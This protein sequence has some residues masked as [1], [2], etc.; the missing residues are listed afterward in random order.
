MEKEFFDLT[1]PQKSIWLTEQYYSNTNINNVCGTFYSSEKLDF[2]LLKKSLNIFLRNNDSFKIKLCFTNDEIKQYFCEIEDI[3]FE[4]IDV[5][6]KEEQTTLENKVA[7]KVFNLI[8]SFLFEIVLF[9]YP[10]NSGG[11]VINSHH[12]ISD[13]WSN[14][15]VANEVAL[16]YD[17]VKNNEPYEKS[18]EL[19]YKAYLH[20]EKDYL[21]STKFEKDK[22]YWEEVFSTVPEVATIPS[23]KNNEKDDDLSANRLLLNVN[24]KLLSNIQSY[25]EKNKISLFN[26]FMAVFALYLGRVSNLDEF[27]IGTPILNR[28][29][30]KEKQITG[31]F[32]NTLPLKIN[33]MHDKTF[34][35]NLKNIAINSMA[36]LRHQ[37]YSYQ[38]IIED[39]R[40]KDSNLPM[41]YN[42][43]YSYQITKMNE[44]MDALNHTTSWTFNKTISENLDIHMFEWNESNTINIAYDYRINKYDEQDILALHARILHI[45]EQILENENILLKDI[46]IVTPEEKHKILYEF[47]NTKVDYPRDKTIVDLFEEQVEKTPDNIAVV[48]E[49]QKLTYRELNEKANQLARYMLLEYNVKP[50]DT[51]GVYLKKNIDFIISIF[52][53]LKCNAVYMPIFYDYPVDR[54]SYMINNS[55]CKLL[56]T[57]SSNSNIEL[58]NTNSIFIDSI[59][60]FNSSS[61]STNINLAITVDSLAYIIYTSGSTGNPKGVC[62]SH[63]NL[64]NFVCSFNKYFKII[65]D[66]DSFLSSTNVAFDVSIWEIFVPLLNGAKLYLNT[67][68]II[69]D[70]ILYCNNIIKYNINALYIPP[71]ILNDVFAILKEKKYNKISK[72]LVGVEPITNTTLNKYI[73]LNPNIIIVNGYGPTETTICATALE[74]KK[75]LSDAHTISIGKPLYNNNI[76]ILSHNMLCP[77]NT[78]GEVFVSGDGVGQGYLNDPLKTRG[79]FKKDIFFEGHTMYSTGD[80][81]F[82][83][84]DGTIQFIG[85]KDNQIKLHGYRIELNEIDLTLMKLP[86]ISKSISL[87]IN[88]NIVAYYISNDNLSD[89][90]IKKFLKKELPFY[91]IPTHII[92]LDNWP[93]TING[94]IDKTRLPVPK[95][96]LSNTY[97]APKTITEQTLCNI[98]CSLFDKEKISMDENFF[99][100]GGDS[101]TAIKLQTEALKNGIYINYA[102][103]FANPT[104]KS[105]SDY[106][107]TLSEKEIVHTIKK[108]EQ[109]EYYPISSAQKRMYYSSNLDNN[110]TLYNIAGGII[111]DKLLD[112]NKLQECFNILI[113]RHEALRTHFDI[114]NDEVV[115]VIDDNI[116]FKLSL[117]N[118]SSD[119]LNNIYTD[120]VKP[121]DLSKAPLF[122]VKL[123]KLNNNKELL[124]LDM[125]HIISDG[126]SLN[127]LLQELCDLYN[128]STL[129]EKQIDYK[130]FTLWEREQFETE[131]F[132]KSKEYWLN[133]FKDEIPL[134]NMPTNNPRPSIQRFVGSN[135]YTQLSK[136]VFEKVNETAKKLNITPYMLLLA[137]YYILLSKYTSQDDIVVGTPIVGRELPE[138]SNILG[139]FVNTLALRNKIDHNLTFEEFSKSIKENCLNSFKNQIYPFDMLVK[140]LNIKRDTSRNP[141]FDVMFVYQNNGYPNINFN[142]TK[143]EYFV[144][145]NNI[146]KFDLTLEIIPIDNEYSLRF[147]YCTKLFNE[148]FIKRLSSHYLNILN[149]IL[150]NN[151]IK[152]AD[153]DMLSKEERNKIL[154]EFNNIEAETNNDTF[155]SLF[156]E[157]VKKYPN[158]IALICDNKSLT[159]SELNKKAN[160]L[161]HFLINNNVKQNDIVAIMT[162]RSLET[163]VCML[164]ILKAGAAFV[165]MDPTYPIE[166]TTYYLNDCKAKCLLKQKHLEIPVNN[167]KNIY[168]IDLDITD[169]YGKNTNNP[170]LNIN[171]ESLSYIIYTSGSTG[172]P[173]G[174]V[175]NHIGLANMCKAMTLVLDYLKD[176]PNHTLLS[177]TSTPFDIFVYEI[178]VP[179]SHGMKIVLA[180]NAEHRNPKLVDVLIRKYNVDV[181]TVTPSL[182]KINY[183]NREPNSALANV[184]NMVFGG[185]PL[186]EKF[187]HDLKALSSDITIYNIY[188]P[189]EITVLSNVQNLNGEKEINIGP[190]ILNTKIYILDSDMNPLPIGLTGEIYIGGV[191]VG[192]GYLG[193][194]DLTKQKFIKNPFAEGKMFKSGDIGRWTK[195]GKLQCLGRIDHQ[196]KLRGL[197]VELGEIEKILEA[198]PEIDEAV[199]NKV[200]VNEKEALCAYYVLNS[201]IDESF[202]RNTLREKLPYYMVPTYFM[203]LDCMPYSINRKIDRKALPI[204]NV[205]NINLKRN[206]NTSSSISS[207]AQKLLYIWKSVL[208]ISDIGIE[209]NFFDIGGDSI[210]AIQVQIEAVKAGINIEYSDIFKYPTIKLL[211]SNLKND[212]YFDILPYT[213]DKINELLKNNTDSSLSSIH[214]VKI[215]NILVIGTTGYLGVHLIYEFLTKHKG[216]VYCLIRP[217][218]RIEP[219]QRLEDIFTFYFGK[220]CFNK[221]KNR[222]IIIKGDITLENMGMSQEDIDIVNNKVSAVINSGAL[223]KHYGES[224][225]FED[226][227]VL[228]TQNVVNFCKKYKKRL[229]HI[230]TISVSGNGENA[231]RKEENLLTNK[232]FS[233]Q[234]LYIN[235]H[236]NGIYTYTKF[237][238]ESIVLNAILEGLD[239]LILRVGNVTNRY[240]DGVF[241]R[242]YKDN[243]FAK[244]IKTFIEIGAFPDYFL[245]HEIELTPVDLCAEAIVRTLYYTSNCNVLH[246][247][248]SNL[249][250]IQLFANLLMELDIKIIPVSHIMMRDIITGILEDNDRKDILS[251][252]IYDLDNDKNLVYTSNIT[253]NSNFSN[254]YLSKI[255][256]AWKKINKNYL[257]RCFKY[258]N[259]IGF[260][261]F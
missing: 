35:E 182:M 150:E 105:L 55:K 204:P 138:L 261:K 104:I 174:V 148:G 59:S 203:K 170:N 96:N 114:V 124:L 33:L 177:V 107:S 56:I 26:F 21:S 34:I 102:D 196:V 215:N 188:G 228:G 82:W 51:V 54:I 140:D 254:K 252:I 52:A 179:L 153:I 207:D 118:A 251:G 135:Y 78:P 115:Q 106:I 36:L 235:Q 71:N 160:S 139:M 202:L 201:D 166:R 259:K 46:E 47:N 58:I 200:L 69:N 247:Y 111:V 156:E 75:D 143:A 171:L 260:I 141:L 199:V 63:K 194:E 72:L 157:Q 151:K 197:R 181:M 49:D 238:A 17:K 81:A 43:M 142:N 60:C 237:K 250:S 240:S 220:K 28:T 227:N 40:K 178:I 70:I 214:K 11:F 121:F 50:R 97:I 65:N 186:S 218:N 64:V 109:R 195:D 233:E 3:D 113:N 14:S 9:R 99:D 94:K 95:F 62:I 83:N 159:Y 44:N 190:P 145:D 217:K 213:N 24:S 4:V 125:H 236:V 89:T 98:W 15:L 224:K 239:A 131:E 132:K 149:T 175:L 10:D 209:D 198:I 42:V 208:N 101:L 232:I 133:E 12:I 8:N 163:V 187:V 152:I 74:Y 255:G 86:S 212:K 221:Y 27:V 119:D 68:D 19:S 84:S 226:I 31:M 7:S 120:F 173:K 93:L 130:D 53:I 25:C 183:D 38:Y 167:F 244:R 108:T 110:S 234:N 193:K 45:I 158:N 13:S 154:Y 189:S 256:F 222:M 243:A 32:I 1:A 155:V 23:I 176:A 16:I 241:Q 103:I 129:S 123:V 245:E 144:P 169:I 30:F 253:L 210:S 2:E 5:K 225:L 76:Y 100:L 48:F 136:E 37:K 248:N 246:I 39:L 231:H 191:Q 249:L 147:E 229:L 192:C 219:H 61:I 112:I 137:V 258:F 117:E 77:I 73:N 87:L 90:N 242:N 79:S 66:D 57:A 67:T 211:T 126:S 85:R 41:L 29:N 18:K 216:N 92:K 20:A 205:N 22:Q 116:D 88:N 223:V 172:T 122:R 180:N 184:K 127:I 165:N 164:A 230:S 146:S 185:E 168:E 162:D 161:A 91:M 206:V 134:L 80:I 6:N 128:G 257:K